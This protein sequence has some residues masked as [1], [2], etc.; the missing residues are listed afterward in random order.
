MIWCTR[1]IISRNRNSHQWVRYITEYMLQALV[2]RRIQRWREIE[3][4][5]SRKVFLWSDGSKVIGSMLKAPRSSILLLA[6]FDN[7]SNKGYGNGHWKFIYPYID[8]YIYI[9]WSS[10]LWQN[11]FNKCRL[12]F[13]AFIN[14]KVRTCFVRMIFVDIK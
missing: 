12:T 10:F 2:G 11:D 8:V 5:S 7:I 3:A 14:H 6:S 9:Q 13:F 4:R 1:W